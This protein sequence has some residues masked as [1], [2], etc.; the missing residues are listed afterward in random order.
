MRRIFSLLLTLA[1]ALGLCACGQSGETKWQEQ[2]DLGL[3]YLSEGNYQEAVVAFT[4][5]IEIDPKR[6]E[7]YEKDAEAYTAAGRVDE[8]PPAA[9]SPALPD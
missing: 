7:A 8:D 4:A 3:R 5:A 6:P 1:L 2:Y 9:L